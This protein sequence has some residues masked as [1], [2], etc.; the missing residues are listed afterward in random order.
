MKLAFQHFKTSKKNWQLIA[1][2]AVLLFALLIR[3]ILYTGPVCCDQW[4][5]TYLAYD[6][7][8]G[9]AGF[10]PGDIRGVTPRF[11][12]YL[13]IGFFY[14]LLGPS[15]FSTV[16]YPLI[17]SLL[18][19]AFVYG[20]A[21]LLAGDKAGLIAALIWAAFPLGIF[22]STSIAP[23]A[24]LATFTLGA[25]YFLLLSRRSENNKGVFLFLAIL[26]ESFAILVK[27]LAVIIL[28]FIFI[29]LLAEIYFSKQKGLTSFFNKNKWASTSV[30][31]S[32]VIIILV[33]EF[34]LNQGSNILFTIQRTATDL[35]SNWV[36]GQTTQ[37]L[38][39]GKIFETDALLLAMPLFFVAIFQLTRE[40]KNGWWFIFLWLFAQFVYYE[41]GSIDTNPL[42]YYPMSSFRDDRNFLFIVAPFCVAAGMYLSGFFSATWKPAS[43]VAACSL[44]LPLALIAKQS[45]WSGSIHTVLGIGA[46]LTILGAFMLPKLRANNSVRFRETMASVFLLVLITGFQYPAPPYHLSYEYWKRQQNYAAVIH[47]AAAFFMQQTDLR[48]LSLSRDNA[49][50]LD[51]LSGFKLGYQDQLLRYQVPEARIFVADPRDFSGSAYIYLRDEINQL[52]PVPSHWWKAAEFPTSQGKPTAIYRVLSAEDARANLQAAKELAAAGQ[53]FEDMENLLGAAINAQDAGTAVRAW[54]ALNENSPGFYAIDLVAPTLIAQAGPLSGQQ[55]LLNSE[56]A[57]GPAPL[58]VDARIE[59]MTSL[60]LGGE[61]R[62]TVNIQG[63]LGGPFGVY[64]YVDLEPET[65]Y[66]FE[67]KVTSTAGVD[68]LRVDRGH[69]PDSTNFSNIY[70]SWTNVS[71][72]FITPNWG[73]VQSV[74]LDYLVVDQGG[75]IQATNPRLY[76]LEFNLP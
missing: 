20:I 46:M 29:F 70:G 7:S 31:L 67:I 40:R 73:H 58:E 38:P 28:L 32:V 74:R 62:I 27:L 22:L 50:E 63:D 69:V 48:I 53:D 11:A 59:D 25:V 8:H 66:L 21:R 68:L 75:I 9:E 30:I 42:V 57:G 71:V 37:D 12:L 72:I 60:D 56:F 65:A 45:Q 23:D 14:W 16:I 13:P 52:E 18:G 19:V 47:E 43:I 33:I 35:S 76:K 24:I 44:A 54:I 17:T 26:F 51:V 2:L 1:L 49:Q 5:Y 64:E 34:G 39:S 41:W 61:A 6:A 55:N 10:S 36:L 15:E 4:D 3:I